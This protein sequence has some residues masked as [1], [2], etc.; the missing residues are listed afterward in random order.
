VPQSVLPAIGQA[1]AI[2]DL[3]KIQVPLGG[4]GPDAIVSILGE[5]YMGSGCAIV[6][7]LIDD[8]KLQ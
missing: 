4:G 7:A 8:V 3:Q 1:V 2:G 5:S 6:S